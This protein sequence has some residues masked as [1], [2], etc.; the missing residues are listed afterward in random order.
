MGAALSPPLIFG[1]RHWESNLGPPASEGRPPQLSYTCNF[2]LVLF[3]PSP[4]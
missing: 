1:R 2:P 4:V 3:L